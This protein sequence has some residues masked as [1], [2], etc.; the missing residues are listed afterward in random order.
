MRV[1]YKLSLAAA[2]LAAGS[3]AVPADAHSDNEIRK[4]KRF[5]VIY[6]ENHS[7]DNLYGDWEGVNGRTPASYIP[8]VNQAGSP[9]GCLLQND[10]S[11]TSPSPL[12]VSCTDAENDI[13]SAFT[14]AEFSIDT[15]IP[16]T[17]PTC[18][19]GYD[20]GDSYNGG[21]T[22]DIVHRYY[23]QIYQLNGGKLNRYVTGSDAV[24]LT[25]GYYDTRQLP[26]YRYLHQDGHPNYAI[27]DNFF[28]AAF[29]G[30][31][32]NHQWLIAANTPTWPNAVNDGSKKDLHSVV[33][34]NGMPT[35]YPLYTSPASYALN[36]AQLTASCDPPPDRG[37]TPPGVVCGDYAVNTTQ[38]TN[39]P[40]QPGTKD[41]KLLPLQTAPTVGDRLTAAGVS[42]AWYSGGWSNAA[43]NI[44]APGWTNGLGPNCADPRTIQGSTFPNCPDTWF[45]FHHQPFNYFANF[46]TRTKSGLKNRK[47]HLRDEIE[48]INLAQTSK[49]K[50]KLKSV[51]FV[52]P[53]GQGNEHPGYSSEPIGSDH[54]VVLLS[55][56]ENSACAKDTMVIV[57]YDEFGGQYDH[58]QPPGQGNDKGPHDKW[59]PG[60]RIPALIVSPLLPHAFSVDGTQ[61]DTTSILATL[62]KRYGLA[63]V[64]DR[65]AQVNNLFSVFDAAPANA[66]R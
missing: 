47:Q 35:N 17:A 29:G 25:V 49:K 51:S 1:A 12:P 30:S 5:V 26:I 8:Q 52:K 61:Y 62:E 2:F 42:W 37:P 40:F 60:N 48:F 34:G 59:G 65:D 19:G 20:Q 45:Q 63:P 4:I 55:A 7:F 11:L 10:P 33:D 31:F 32:L 66:A 57:T 3:A 43:G 28:H 56:I 6:Q 36:D 39:Q 44:G 41:Y 16:A 22:E 58:V 53:L 13:A 24:G 38:P 14:N 46:S 18:T 15:Y 9:Y 54:L 64:A 27:L 23:Q 21:C 50:C